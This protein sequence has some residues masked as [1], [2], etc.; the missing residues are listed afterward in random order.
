MAE[1]NFFQSADNIY[2]SE[3]E[4]EKGLSLELEPDLRSQ[5]VGLIEDRFANAE[6]ARESGSLPKPGADRRSRRATSD[7]KLHRAGALQWHA[8]RG[9]QGRV[10]CQ[11]AS[12]T[13]CAT[14]ERLRRPWRA[15]QQGE[16]RR[17]ASQMLAPVRES[18]GGWRAWTHERSWCPL[19]ASSTARKRRRE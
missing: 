2:L 11:R 13:R 3:V 15:G 16:E 17:A 4:G 5:F 18:V 6:T 7:E 10:G 8:G 9:C 12:C 19:R 1:D 14:R